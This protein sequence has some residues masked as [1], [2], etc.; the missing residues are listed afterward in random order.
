MCSRERLTD[1]VG[2]F[3]T[4][5]PKSAQITLPYLEWLYTKNPDGMVIGF[6]AWYGDDLVAH[7]ASIPREA[8]FNGKTQKIILTLNTATHPKHR[9]KGLFTL[10]AKASYD[11]ARSEGFNAVIAVANSNSTPGFIKKLDF[12][13]ITPLSIYIGVGKFN[14][15]RE[16][17]ERSDCFRLNWNKKQLTWRLNCPTREV[18]MNSIKEGTS[19]FTNRF[20]KLLVPYS[21]NPFITL[22]KSIDK[23]KRG[24]SHFLRVVIGITPQNTVAKNYYIKLIENLK[25]TPLNFIFKSLDSDTVPPKKDNIFFSF[26][27][28]DIL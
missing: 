10:L 12:Q 4:A 6:D 5:F 14:I 2:L 19:F 16:K 11:K 24:S 18:F 28:F 15:I 1:Y 22:N 9:S 17:L 20:G 23:G 25:P 13:L 26:L 21:E 27:D 7:C 8:V 3:T